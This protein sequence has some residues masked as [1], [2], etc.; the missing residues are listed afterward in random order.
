MCIFGLWLFWGTDQCA[1]GCALRRVFKYYDAS[2]VWHCCR[3]RRPRH[4][5]FPSVHVSPHLPVQSQES[6]QAW[7]PA[8]GVCFVTDSSH[9][10]QQNCVQLGP[11][12]VLG[13]TA[14][15]ARGG[16]L[17]CVFLTLA[18]FSLTQTARFGCDC[19]PNRAV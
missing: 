9:I 18:P 2:I 6:M 10:S 15:R 4:G 7:D 13:S 17:F 19:H 16:C 12:F 1:P 5:V 11:D 3:S 14:S 8:Y